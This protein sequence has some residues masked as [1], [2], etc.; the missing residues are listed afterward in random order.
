MNEWA[1]SC[2][3]IGMIIYSQQ[4]VGLN[5]KE[6]LQES[7]TAKRGCLLACMGSTLT[8]KRRNVQIF[9]AINALKKSTIKNILMHLDI[10]MQA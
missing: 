6:K 2:Q 9:A 3:E 10:I 7:R 8:V 1:F 4:L 5:I